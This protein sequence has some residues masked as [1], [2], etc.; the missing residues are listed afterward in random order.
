MSVNTQPVEK[1]NVL[2]F[3]RL[4]KLIPLLAASLFGMGCGGEDRDAG[5]AEP[6]QNTL[7]FTNITAPAGLDGFVHQNGSQ[8]DKW[9]PEAMGGGGGFIDIDGDGWL[10]ILLVE[11]GTWQDDEELPDNKQVNALRLYR[12]SGD[13]TFRDYTSAAGLGQVHAYP[14]GVVV[15]DY[16]ND[17]DDDFFL[18][19]LNENLLFQ[20]T[21][22]RF[23]EVGANAGLA[24]HKYW[25]TAAVFFD[26]DRDGWLD[27]F[28]ADYVDW[29][30]ESNASCTNNGVDKS[31]CGAATYNGLQNHFYKG[32]GDGTFS[33]ASISVGLSVGAGKTLGVSSLDFNADGWTDL[34]LTNHGEPDL[35]YQNE[36]DGTF[37]E[38]GVLS[39]M[40]FDENGI[41][42]SGTGIDAGDVDNNGNMSVFV[43]NASGEQIGVYR[44]SNDSVFTHRSVASQI[45]QRST[46]SFGFGLFLFDPNL[47]GY[48]DLFVANG[49]FDDLIGQNQDSLFYKQV[50]QLFVNRRN[51]TFEEAANEKSDLLEKAIAGRG[52][53]FGDIDR[54]GDQ[55]VL[56]LEN[57]GAAYLWRNDSRNGNA[58]RVYLTGTESN[59]DGI[60]AEVLA[61]VAG[62]P[63]VRHM[64]TGGSYLSQSER[65]VTIGLGMHH[66]VDSVF[67]SWPSGQRDSF[68]NVPAGQ[69]IAVTEGESVYQT[70]Y[71]F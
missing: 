20:N 53:A 55:D 71:A 26:A 28:V 44:Y 68:V 11:G 50:P 34:A 40:A 52:A 64:R 13:G 37:E 46:M 69:A 22:G 27:L 21:D 66:S 60:G 35:L 39:G 8:G 12:N 42:M 43:A 14:F 9:Y 30:P 70:L 45:G 61:Y 23:L 6:E 3:V 54:D 16:D 4:R 7:T 5:V 29:A 59:T 2:S 1:I 17:G 62:E 36:G 67:V 65:V 58:L 49:H 48:L 63:Q 25:S 38:V 31:Y 56:V 18:T 19:T 47:D 32:N 10:D 24:R 15:A 41:A 33:E 57:N 51:G